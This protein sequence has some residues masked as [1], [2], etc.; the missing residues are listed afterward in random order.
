MQTRGLPVPTPTLQHIFSLSA[1]SKCSLKMT[2]K[3][4]KKIYRILFLER[5]KNMNYYF[6]NVKME[7]V[8]QCNVRRESEDL[9]GSD[10]RRW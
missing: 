2:P 9:E 7:N 8:I 6:E 1:S 10:V 5:S 4:R 3:S